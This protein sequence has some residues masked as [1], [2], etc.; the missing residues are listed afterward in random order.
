MSTLTFGKKRIEGHRLGAASRFPAILP[1]LKGKVSTSLGEDEGLFIGYGSKSDALPYTMQCDYDGPLE[2]L[3]FESA[4]LENEHLRAEVVISLG[5]RLWSLYDKDAKRDIIL[6][7]HQFLPGNLAIRNAWF[8]GGVEWNTGSFGHDAQTCETRFAAETADD[9]GTPV[10]RIFEF[11]RDAAVPFQ[12]DFFLPDGSKFLYVRVRI[13]NIND[14]TVPMYWWSNIAVE[15]RKGARVIV[16]TDE[17]YGNHYDKGNHSI[18][19][20]SLPD[21]CGFD[22]TYPTNFGFAMDHFYK[23]P[24]Q[25]RKYETVFFPDGYG[26]VHCSTRRLQGRKLFVWGQG[27]G[28]KHWQRSLMAPDCPDYIEIQA[29]LAHLQQECL[30]MPPKTSWEWLEAYGAIRLAPEKC[31]GEWKDAVENVTAALDSILPEATLDALLARTRDSIALKRAA[32]KVKGSGWGALEALLRK[33]DFAPQ[34]DYGTPD[35]AQNEWRMLLEQGRMD[36]GEP[37]SFMVQDEWFDLL[38]NATHNWKSLYHLAINYCH[39]GDM[40]RAEECLGKSLALAQNAWNIHAAAYFRRIQ[41]RT[42]ESAALFLKAL[43]MERDDVSLAKDAMKSLV[44]MEEYEYA[45]IA[46]DM[47]P[48]ALQERPLLKCL[49]ANALAHTGRIGEAERIL[50]EDGGIDVPDIREG[51]VST[52]NLYIYIQMEKARISG[53][54]LDAG[55]VAVPLALDFR[56]S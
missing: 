6:D 31:F 36:D 32:V 52:S 4:V 38:K 17:T 48:A 40:E 9:D 53:L 10:L 49:Y 39:R 47:L 8:A 56:M 44:A 5:G 7:N 3:E 18:A 54:A 12:L 26:V 51:E 27:V 46:Y 15:E 33:G 11:N 42:A 29:G 35:E 34:L 24:E 13:N 28:G 25:S 30:P 50:T 22:G 45:I 2:P 19:K 14:R 55:Q 43:S 16:P 20:L 1:A 23:I 41:G 37:K 21:G